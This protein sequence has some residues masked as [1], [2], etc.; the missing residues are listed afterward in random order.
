LG[1][2]AAS[3][4]VVKRGRQQLGRR[5]SLVRDNVGDV[6]EGWEVKVKPDSEELVREGWRSGT[7]LFCRRL[8]EGTE[9][10]AEVVGHEEAQRR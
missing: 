5:A 10:R 7:K 2:G 8:A 4:G 9:A 3:A 1:D 6:G